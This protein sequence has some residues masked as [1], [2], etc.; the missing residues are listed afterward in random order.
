MQPIPAETLQRALRLAQTYGEINIVL[1]RKT[2]RFE[3]LTDKEFDYDENQSKQLVLV[4]NKN[5]TYTMP[6]GSWGHLKK[7]KS[8][9]LIQAPV[10]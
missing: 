3:C 10:R 7:D 6:N 1:N 2:D 4:V 5:H 9:R 8:G